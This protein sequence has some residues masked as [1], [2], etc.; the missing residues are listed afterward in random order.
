MS[1]IQK[2]TWKVGS[3]GTALLYWSLCGN[4]LVAAISSSY[5]DFNFLV[6]TCCWIGFYWKCYGSEIVIWWYTLFLFRRF[7]EDILGTQKLWC[8]FSSL[9]VYKVFSRSSARGFRLHDH[10]S[11]ATR[12]S[13]LM[14]SEINSQQWRKTAWSVRINTHSCHVCTAF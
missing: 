4:N 11:K 1:W 13:W 5:G 6:I 9:I 7:E 8:I 12:L 14:L 3:L 2:G 10:S